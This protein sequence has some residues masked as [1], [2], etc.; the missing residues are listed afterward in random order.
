[1]GRHPAAIPYSGALTPQRGVTQLPSKGQEPAPGAAMVRFA[2]S[3]SMVRMSNQPSRCWRKCAAL[4][5]L[6]TLASGLKIPLQPLQVGAHFRRALV[7]EVAV[8]L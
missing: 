8:L 5:A 3:L 7:A 1:M 6:H 2:P 4:T